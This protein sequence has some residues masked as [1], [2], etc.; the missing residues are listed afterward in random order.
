MYGGMGGAE[1]QSFPLSRSRLP[2]QDCPPHAGCYVVPLAAA[3]FT[4]GFFLR[5]PLFRDLGAGLACFA[6]GDCNGLLPAFHLLPA[7]AGLQLP[8]LVLMHYL[9]DF[10][11]STAG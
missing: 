2:W 9:L 1:E 11:F 6:E 5:G 7:A 10:T 4:R 3:L 8:V